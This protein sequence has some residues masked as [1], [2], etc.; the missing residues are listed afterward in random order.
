MNIN[1]IDT[2]K[3]PMKVY[4]H[5]GV[6]MLTF[7]VFSAL[8][9]VVHGVSTRLGGV[10]KGIY[11]SM[12]FKEDAEDS[13]ENIRENY[14]RTAAALGCDRNKMVRPELAHKAFVHQ[15]REQDYGSGCVREATLYDIDA[16]ITD[17]PGVT[18]A[19][20]FADCV[21]LLFV[22]RKHQAIGLAHSGWRG[23]VKK[24]GRE[25]L[26]AMK[27]AFKT[28]MEDVTAAIGPCICQDCYEVGEDVK[29]EFQT[30]FPGT[31]DSDAGKKPIQ[32][33]EKNKNNRYQLDLQ[34]ANYRILLEAGLEPS[35]IQ[36][37]DICTC[38][39]PHLLFSH[40]ATNGKRGAIGVFLGIAD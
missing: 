26:L 10:S 38:C 5:N 14:R 29:E 16:L 4:E 7:P 12:N 39:N 31:G 2:G 24:I 33:I 34:M 17:V 11:E 1:R 19:A 15:V 21:P 3:E 27:E 40:R 20:T 32:I 37:S 6:M 23:T 8:P 22:D 25:T 28:R 30:I 18:L 13:I 9:W 36:I 35:Q